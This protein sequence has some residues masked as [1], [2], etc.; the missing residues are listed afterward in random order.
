MRSLKRAG[1]VMSINKR[2]LVSGEIRY[3]AILSQR[4]KKNRIARF[5]TREEAEH[6][7]RVWRAMRPRKVELPS[8]DLKALSDYFL[9]GVKI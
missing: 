5:G 1:A 7:I 8:V 2:R 9:L 6:Q 4:N 3:E